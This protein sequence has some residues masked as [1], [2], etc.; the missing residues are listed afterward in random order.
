MHDLEKT[1]KA[2][3]EILPG[4]QRDFYRG[5]VWSGRRSAAAEPAQERGIIYDYR[6]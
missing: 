3:G 1:W 5:T 2:A 6:S 4:C